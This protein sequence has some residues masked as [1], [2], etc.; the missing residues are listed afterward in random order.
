MALV[1]SRSSQHWQDL[2]PASAAGP[3]APTGRRCSCF[4]SRGRRI[5]RSQLERL[6][7]AKGADVEI[8]LKKFDF[9][10]A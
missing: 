3:R 8:E 2:L 6:L 10:F 1:G 5:F 9:A 7:C 4:S